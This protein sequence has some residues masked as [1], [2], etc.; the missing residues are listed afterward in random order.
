MFE[1]LTKHFEEENWKMETGLSLWAG[2]KNYMSKDQDL[3]NDSTHW[4]RQ[5][6]LELV[7]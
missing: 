3:G 2:A 6:G 5:S 7:S 4:V 1:N